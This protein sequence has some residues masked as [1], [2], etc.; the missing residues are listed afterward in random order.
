MESIYKNDLDYKILKL[1]NGKKIIIDGYEYEIIFKNLLL[2]HKTGDKKYYVI[3][4]EHYDACIEC[5]INDKIV[6]C[7]R[8]ITNLEIGLIKL[9]IYNESKINDVT[10]RIRD[11]FFTKKLVVIRLFKTRKIIKK[12]NIG[13]EKLISIIT[14]NLN[15]N[16]HSFNNNPGEIEFRGVKEIIF[17]TKDCI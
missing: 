14:K 17:L 6:E 5:Y 1:L 12:L 8:R 15:N 10:Y 13:N 3:K 16:K 2:C 4:I 9:I 7:D 11:D